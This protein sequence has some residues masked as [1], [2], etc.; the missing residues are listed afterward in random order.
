[1][2][3]ILSCLFSIAIFFV[4]GQALQNSIPTVS[5]IHLS[6]L[7]EGKIHKLWLALGQDAFSNSI[8]IPVLIAKGSSEGP[9]LGLTAALHGNELNGIPIIQKLFDELDVVN[10]K[11]TLIAVP[12]LN[13]AAIFND[14]RRF[15]DQE[16]LNRN[17]PGKANGNRSQQ[18]A[19]QIDQKIISL[20]DF[21][22]D[23]HTAS[24]GRVNSMYARADMENDTLAAMAKLQVPD[25]ILSNKGKPSFGAGSSIT[26]R[27][28]A[29][30]KEIHSITVEYG[31]PQVYQPEMI[32]RGKTGILNLMHWLKM[33]EGKIVMVEPKV[34]CSKS[35][36]I[37]IDTGGLLEIP[38]ELNQKVTQGE[39]IG[40]LKN[41]F[42][43]VIKEYVAPEDGIVIGKSTNPANM[44]G[45]RIIHLGIIK[46]P[47]N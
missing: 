10:L 20:F 14:K 1:M 2:K 44:S 24:F 6:A 36:W 7:A 22:V 15:I 13:P 18:M 39:L 38:V 28:S 9:V 33:T 34:V 46:T 4:Q 8:K 42:G 17:F 45:G 25:I 16:D 32:G 12:G 37:Y 19:Y 41:P 29:I 11:G 27:A 40:I 21:H 43:D 35:Y 47:K 3:R 30:S 26:M 5:D 23:M 31:N